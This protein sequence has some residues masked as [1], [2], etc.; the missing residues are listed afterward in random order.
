MIHGQWTCDSFLRIGKESNI[1]DFA[2]LNQEGNTNK[3]MGLFSNQISRDE[4]KAGDHIYSW[5]SYVYS[6]HGD[7]KVIHFTRGGGLEIGTGTYLDKII[8]SS[9]PNHGGD[10]PCLDCGD[11]SKLDGV[12]SSC[13]DCFLSGGKLYIFEYN[14]S[15]A[16][17]LAKQRGGT[18][19]TAPSDPCHEV[20]SRAEFLLS[21]NGFGVYD[22]VDNNC[23]DFAIYCKTGLIALSITKSGSSTQVNSVC[24]AGSF[25]SLTL[26]VLGV[27]KSGQAASMASPALMVSAATN[28]LTTTLGLV[29]SGFGAMAVV[30]YGN[31]CM[32]RLKSDIGVRTDVIKVPVERLVAVMSIIDGRLDNNN[33]NKCELS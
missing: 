5:R 7:A 22:L 3:K 26:K 4:L 21:R 31:Y 29:Y 13:L 16:L 9:V 30:G 33:N 20:I 25:V 15:K 2:L 32:G 12:I 19:T 23:E 11:Q 10:K 17:F 18:C 8:V 6:H 24:A 28:A 14:V 27:G 1:R